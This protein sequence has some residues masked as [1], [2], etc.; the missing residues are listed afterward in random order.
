MAKESSPQSPRPEF[1]HVT[2]KDVMNELQ[3]KMHK[4]AALRT[5]SQQQQ[6][7]PQKHPPQPQVQPNVQQPPPSPK[8]IINGLEPASSNSKQDPVFTVKKLPF[9]NDIKRL[10]QSEVHSPV[11]TLPTPAAPAPAFDSDTVGVSNNVNLETSTI[12]PHLGYLENRPKLT[13]FPFLDDIR[14]LRKDSSRI[15]PNKTQTNSIPVHDEYKSDYEPSKTNNISAHESQDVDRLEQTARE[16]FENDLHKY[17]KEKKLEASAAMQIPQPKLIQSQSSF[18]QSPPTKSVRFSTVSPDQDLIEAASSPRQDQDYA[19]IAAFENNIAAVT[20]AEEDEGESKSAPRTPKTKRS[21]KFNLKIDEKTNV[22]R[23]AD[24]M[25]PQLNI[26]QKNFL[27]LLFFNELSQ[28]IVD[29]I[30]AQ[31]LS[32]M[33]GSKLA[34][35]L[36]SLD[37]QV[38]TEH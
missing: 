19:A 14:K 5:Q 3:M 28:N 2:E 35:V 32:M 37:P 6:Q 24:Q 12:S 31:Q 17:N 7:V 26:M 29:D 16:Q 15:S 34:S 22:K 9:L 4:A 25:I 8:I 18:S 23:L 21:S 10:R 11:T 36:S 20:R 27:G 13:E 1:N 30:V 38:R 33:P